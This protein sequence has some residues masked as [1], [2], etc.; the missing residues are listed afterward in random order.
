[1]VEADGRAEGEAKGRKE[2]EAK[3]RKEGKAEGRAEGRAE[4]EAK[5][6]AEGVASVITKLLKSGFTADVIASATGLSAA[7]IQKYC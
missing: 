5:G 1:M 2:G 6:R 7:E 4:G 3:G